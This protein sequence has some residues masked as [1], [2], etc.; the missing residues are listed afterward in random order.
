MSA[1]LGSDQNVLEVIS[2]FAATVASDYNIK[3]HQFRIILDRDAR[4]AMHVKGGPVIQIALSWPFT[5]K[6]INI[7]LRSAFNLA[8]NQKLLH[9][10]ALTKYMYEGQPRAGYVNL[11]RKKLGP[12]ADIIFN[13]VPKC[14][15]RVTKETIVTL[16]H[17]E[18]GEKVSIHDY[19]GHRTTWDI[20]EEGRFYL[21]KTLMPAYVEPIHESLSVALVSADYYEK[22]AANWLE[23]TQKYYA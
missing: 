13:M 21:T 4:A 3:P 22:S 8:I 16:T 6:K 9:P 23:I 17:K 7:Y 15:Y 12:D 20:E 14:D 18:T 19:T 5:M 2:E 1:K 11:L 10:V